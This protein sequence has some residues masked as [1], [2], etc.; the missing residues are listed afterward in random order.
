MV[1]EFGE[2]NSDLQNKWAQHHLRDSW[3][4]TNRQHLSRDGATVQGVNYALVRTPEAHAQAYV[5][6][7][8]YISPKARH[9]EVYYFETDR[10]CRTD[11]IM[12][13]AAN[14]GRMGL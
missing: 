8:A 9:G 3:G 6:V 5:L 10:A 12:I 2:G 13:F 1:S 11:L 14:V 4:M 7:D